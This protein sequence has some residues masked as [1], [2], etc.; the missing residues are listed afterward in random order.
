M[1][2]VGVL[3]LCCIP[4]V[5][6]IV[7]ILYAL[8]ESAVLAP[9]SKAVLI[10]PVDSEKEPVGEMLRVVRFNSSGYTTLV[11]DRRGV[12]RRPEKLL[13]DGLCDDVVDAAHLRDAVERLV[14]TV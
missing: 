14:S 2:D 7:T 4:A 9:L 3:L 1:S 6:G 13:R 8:F 11:L 5:I 10:L 12:I